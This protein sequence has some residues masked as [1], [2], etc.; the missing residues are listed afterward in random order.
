MNQS[1]LDYFSSFLSWPGYYVKTIF[2]YKKTYKNFFHVFLKS[3]R[4]NFPIT[5]ILKNGDM[6][7]LKSRF[8]SGAVTNNF[9]DYFFWNDDVLH[10][11]NPNL[12]ELKFVGADKNGDIQAVFFDEVYA[13]LDVQD[14]IVVD[15]GANIGDTAIY[16]AIKGAKKVIALE[17]FSQNYELAKK[18]I[19]L[20]NLT[21]KIEL[22]QAGCSGISG[23]IKI[24]SES[25]G[26]CSI[27]SEV[28]E[29]LEI[30]LLSLDDI[31]K[32]YNIDS[33]ILKIDCEGCEQDVILNSS[34]KTL[35]KFSQIFI[36]YHYGYKDLKEKL[37][38]LNFL[39]TISRP[40]CNPL[41]SYPMQI[42][43]IFSEQNNLKR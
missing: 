18:N 29:G 25:D 19:E 5:A 31:V 3:F 26:P 33:G 42:G 13:E 9:Q 43:D 1:I 2:R 24:S 10:V 35:Q 8:D 6:I 12:S 27:L 32:K 34:E 38:K 11:T 41:I 15:I 28:S 36:E 39:S 20:N 14:K 7:V 17:P 37:T 4:N 30:P 40:T 21:D 16:F 23:T 22:I